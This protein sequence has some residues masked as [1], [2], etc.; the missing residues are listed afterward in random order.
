MTVKQLIQALQK[1]DP[2]RLVVCSRDAEGNGYSPLDQIHR[3]AYLAETTWSGEVG[4]EKL[5]AAD[6]R[7]GYSQEDVCKGGVPA[8]ILVPTN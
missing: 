8:L 1:E 6:R 3:A 7:A 2:N 4:L 5:T